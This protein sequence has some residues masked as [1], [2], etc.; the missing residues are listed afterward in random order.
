M[1]YRFLF[2]L[3]NWVARV[4][5]HVEVQG[6][7]HMPR[8]GVLVVSNHLT[9][10]DPLFIGM[11]F[12]RELHFMAKIE[13]FQNPLLA[14]TITALGAFPVRRGE[15]DR[16]ALRQAE[17]LLRSG[18]VVA[19]FPEGHRSRQGAVQES[20]GGIA[21]LARRA[22]TPILPVAITGTEHFRAASLRRWRPWRRPTVT[23]TVGEPFLL[24]RTSGR[25]DYDALAA[26]I[27]GR[28]AALLPPAYQG[29]YA[30]TLAGG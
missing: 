24:P 21:L 5:A 22:G 4:I 17:E 6:N 3:V 27:M 18:R 11:C 13:L 30:E 1:L 12:K 9:N 29:V 20:K 7:D 2:P 10:F 14:R 28:V 8:G 16:A 26:H 25:A 23:I 15:A 19:I